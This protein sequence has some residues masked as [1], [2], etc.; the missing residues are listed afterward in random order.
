MTAIAQLPL[1]QVANKHALSE[2]VKW[3]QA[4]FALQIAYSAQGI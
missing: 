2:L 1:P 4:Q 3:L